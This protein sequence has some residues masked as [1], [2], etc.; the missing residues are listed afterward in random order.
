MEYENRAK[1]FKESL[2][3]KIQDISSSSTGAE[4]E[5]YRPSCWAGQW[6][7]P[8][9]YRCKELI[10]SFHEYRMGGKR[11]FSKELNDLISL[12]GNIQSRLQSMN[13]PLYVVLRALVPLLTRWRLRRQEYT[14]MISIRV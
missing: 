14:L 6:H 4:Y 1:A 13:R 8:F 2:Q 7:L 9:D 10:N 3:K 11:E 5:E 12:Y